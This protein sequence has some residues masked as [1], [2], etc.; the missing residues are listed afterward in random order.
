MKYIILTLTYSFLLGCSSLHKDELM[1]DKSKA[2]CYKDKFWKI[3]CFIS[4]D[5]LEDINDRYKPKN[6]N[7]Y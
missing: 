4:G 3:P 1:L 5:V 6:E 2:V 7:S